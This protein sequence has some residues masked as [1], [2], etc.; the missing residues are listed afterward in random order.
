MAKTLY[1]ALFICSKWKPRKGGSF[2]G[3]GL[4]FRRIWGTERLGGGGFSSPPLYPREWRSCFSWGRGLIW[5]GRWMLGGE[6]EVVG[7][8]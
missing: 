5:P 8:G 6:G 3:R 2:R 1:I 4:G 7:V